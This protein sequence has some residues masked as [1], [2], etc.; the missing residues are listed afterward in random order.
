M[1]DPDA[2]D[3]ITASLGGRRWE[4][5][6]GFAVG[7][8]NPGRELFQQVFGFFGLQEKGCQILFFKEARYIAQEG[9]MVLGFF[10]FRN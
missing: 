9:E 3:L 4:S 1:A 8:P 5:C 7:P 10:L 2:D 6:P